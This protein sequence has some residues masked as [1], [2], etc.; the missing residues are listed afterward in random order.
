[1]AGKFQ[2]DP[3]FEGALLR[4]GDVA[5]LLEPFVQQVAARA[6]ELSPDDPDTPGSSI[7]DGI[8]GEVGM[9]K[10]G[11]V[12]RV[13]GF[14]FKTGWFEFGAAGTPARRMLGQAVEEIVGP[15]KAGQ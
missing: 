8:E 4:S 3:G 7:A 14:D 10:D 12:G 15:V 6:R 2:L 13:N 11:F 1:M 5:A 9:S